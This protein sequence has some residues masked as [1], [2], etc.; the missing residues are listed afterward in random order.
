MGNASNEGSLSVAIFGIGEVGQSL[1]IEF[2]RH[3]H[4]VTIISRQ[5][6]S[7]SKLSSLQHAGARPVQVDYS[8]ANS[9]KQAI[10]RVDIVISTLN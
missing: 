6:S 5:G 2:L 7:N 3:N 10:E 8:S 4:P 1:A 9:I